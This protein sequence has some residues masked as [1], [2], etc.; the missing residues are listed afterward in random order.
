MALKSHRTGGIRRIR[1]RKIRLSG[2]D[3]LIGKTGSAIPKTEKM[4]RILA[5]TLGHDMIN[6]IPFTVFDS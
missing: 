6:N 2:L 3:V 5:A 4:S 1:N